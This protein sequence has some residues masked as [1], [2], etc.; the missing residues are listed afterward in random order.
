MKKQQRTYVVEVTSTHRYGL[1]QDYYFRDET[2]AK[3]EM[4]SMKEWFKHSPSQK[5]KITSHN[6]N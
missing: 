5:F 2:E 1:N 3:Q 4:A 6:I